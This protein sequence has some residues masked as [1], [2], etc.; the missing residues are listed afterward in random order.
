MD[1]QALYSDFR[2]GYDGRPE[3]YI[4]FY[5]KNSTY[6]NNSKNLQSP[7]ELKLYIE[8]VS[9]FAEADYQKGY[10]NLSID[11]VDMCQLFIDIEIQ[12]L[13]AEDI[14]DAWYHSLQ[15]VK[16][17]ASYG[18]KDYKTAKIIFESL[19]KND[20]QNDHFKRWLADAK[21]GLNNRIVRGVNVFLI[22]AILLET[23]F[24]SEISYYVRTSILTGSLAGIFLNMA[25]EYY[26]SR[27]SRKKS[28]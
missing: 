14:K 13:H 7:N 12:R 24:R 20:S 17:M 1:I 10:F 23:I 4:G 3:Y 18:L 15:F 21:Y 9:K 26:N 25:Y 6:F 8:M 22:A 5:E 16:G 28:S 27:N 19:I 2:N 11:K